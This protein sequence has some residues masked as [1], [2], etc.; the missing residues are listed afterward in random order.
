MYRSASPRKIRSLNEVK[1]CELCDNYVIILLFSVH[2]ERD[3]NGEQL[4][5]Q[6]G[7]DTAPPAPPA[8]TPRTV[9][10][11]MGTVLGGQQRNVDQ[12]CFA[13]HFEPNV[14]KQVSRSL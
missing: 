1:T 8:E 5:A 12:W 14:L 3:E 6:P 4:L 10:E 9:E 7:D 13:E 11:M 2:F